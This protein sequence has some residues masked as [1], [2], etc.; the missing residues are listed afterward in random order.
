MM[1]EEAKKKIQ[2]T[3]A[4]AVVVAGVRAGYMLYERHEDYVAEE[5]VEQAKKA[6]YSKPISTWG[7]RSL[8]VRSEVGEA[9]DA[10]AGVGERRIPVH[11]LP[12]M[13]ASRKQRDFAHEAGLLGPMERLEM[14][15]VMAEFRRLRGAEASDGHVL[16]RGEELRGAD[17]IRERWA[18]QDLFR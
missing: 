4:L 8:S 5:K 12:L 7:R 17:R 9:V 15:D 16:D 2:I 13:C 14:M 1:S 3:L 11:L 10:T 18:V 6:R